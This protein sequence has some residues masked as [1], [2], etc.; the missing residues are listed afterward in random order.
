MDLVEHEWYIQAP[1]GRIAIIAW[2]D[3]CN[4]PV[5]LCHGSMDSAV[6]F[7]PL[8][9]KLPR[10]YYYIGLDLPG[11]GKSDRFLPGLMIS[12]YDMLYAIHALVKHFRWKTFTLIGHS[13]GAYLVI[14]WGDCCNPPVLLC[15]GSM[16]SAVSFR[17]LVSKLPR[18]YYYI[19]L[20]LPGNGKSDRFLPGLMISVVYDMLYAI[21]ALVK[22]FRW[23]TFTLIG[24]SFGA[25]LGQFYNLC[26]PDKLEL[27]INLDP[28]NFFAVPPEEFSRWYHIFFTNFY[29]NYDKYNTPK[30]KSPTIKWS[31]ALQ[32]L[33]RNRPSLNEEQAAAVL[34]RL[35]EPVGDGCVRYTYDLR[36]KR[37][38]GPA[39]SPEHVK[40]LFTHIFF[41]NFYKNYD[42]YNTPKEKSPTI[43]WTEA[44][45]SLMRNR[46]SLSEEQAAAVLERLSEPVGDGCV[47][48][49]YDLRMKRING[50]A[51]SPE[52]VKKLFTAV[53]TPI[54]T[55]ACEGC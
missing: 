42:K 8:V 23:K 50:P 6:S 54:L 22:H 11:N 19:G 44:L 52:H 34:E 15:H 4:P 37:I 21:H 48:Y 43:K 45:Q 12:V 14:A 13:F 27:L 3:C 25:Y 26:Y 38:N 7:R 53:R 31:E 36:M 24:H 9:S 10:N 18:N 40:K 1:W 39:Y 5:L 49:T 41:T 2:G 33:M 30:E 17:P 20:D 16:D 32:S 35:S 47:R 28:I 55:I 51:Y 29:K 46:P